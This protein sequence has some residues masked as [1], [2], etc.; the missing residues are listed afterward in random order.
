MVVRTADFSDRRGET[1]ERRTP[2][3]SGGKSLLDQD[4]QRRR[5]LFPISKNVKR[6]DVCMNEGEETGSTPVITIEVFIREASPDY[7]HTHNTHPSW[8]IAKEPYPTTHTSHCLLP[9]KLTPCSFPAVKPCISMQHYVIPSD[10]TSVVSSFTK[11]LSPSQV[12][13]ALPH[14]RGIL[15][16]SFPRLS[17]FSLLAVSP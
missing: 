8:P 15:S 9:G 4:H 3:S 13:P 16:W 14:T 11:F 5:N 17:A 2:K 12:R 7:T 10:C 1:H 6:G